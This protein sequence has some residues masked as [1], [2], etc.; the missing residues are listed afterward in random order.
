MHAEQKIWRILIW[1][2]KGIPPNRQI[3]RLLGIMSVKWILQHTITNFWPAVLINS[4]EL[5]NSKSCEKYKG[6]YA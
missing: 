2:F 4:E 5:P 6:I 3:F 1:W